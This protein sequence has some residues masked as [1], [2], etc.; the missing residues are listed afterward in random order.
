MRPKRPVGKA[1]SGKLPVAIVV[2]LGLAVVVA[3]A[4]AKLGPYRDN[5]RSEQN[6]PDVAQIVG[7]DGQVVGRNPTPAVARPVKPV[8]PTRTPNTGNRTVTLPPTSMTPPLTPQL[9][10]VPKPAETPAYV[11]RADWHV[12]HRPTCKY[13]RRIEPVGIVYLLPENQS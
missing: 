13:A 8:S 1:Q 5:G 4:I 9:T 2:I 6:P 10:P 12:Y 7:S 3:F 11:A